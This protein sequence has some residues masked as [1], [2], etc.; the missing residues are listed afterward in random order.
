VVKNNVFA[1]YG[2]RCMET[3][4]FGILANPNQWV[5][6]TESNDTL[7]SSAGILTTPYSYTAPDYRPTNTSIA[8]SNISFTDATLAALTNTVNCNVGISEN[9]TEFGGLALFPNPAAGSVSLKLNT[10]T[11]SELSVIITDVTGK[12]IS[13]PVM[14]Q[15]FSAGENT[16]LINT[17]DLNN[18]LYFVTVSS[19]SGKESMKLI[20]NK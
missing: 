15:N 2:E 16:I 4:T 3:G 18:G 14:N 20:I 5:K 11:S 13:K 12:V 9:N 7:I 6:T 17:S 10:N 19:K 1:G 8:L